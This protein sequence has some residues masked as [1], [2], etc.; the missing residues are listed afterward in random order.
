M[1]KAFT[2]QPPAKRRESEVRVPYGAPSPSGPPRPSPGVEVYYP[3]LQVS[4]VLRSPPPPQHTDITALFSEAPA[5]HACERTC[6]AQNNTQTHKLA[7]AHSITHT[8]TSKGHQVD[9]TEKNIPPYGLCSQTHCLQTE[10]IKGKPGNNLIA[11]H[12]FVLL[13][14]RNNKA[15]LVLAFKTA[16]TPKE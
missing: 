6:S 2:S 11:F 14:M 9:H 4:P 8:R 10:D 5:A 16:L 1:G 13:Y 12:C 3:G 15:A 7:H